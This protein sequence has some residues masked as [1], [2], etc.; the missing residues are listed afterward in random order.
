MGKKFRYS[1]LQKWRELKKVS[2]H[3][4]NPFDH[5]KCTEKRF[6]PICMIHIIY[7]KILSWTVVHAASYRPCWNT[8]ITWKKT[9]VIARGKAVPPGG[10]SR[11]FAKKMFSTINLVEIILIIKTK[12]IRSRYSLFWFARK[13]T[14]FDCWRLP[15]QR[16]FLS[17]ES[18]KNRVW[19]TGSR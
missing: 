1:Q 11:S 10:W 13:I 7:K 4:K 16:W 14:S 5:L 8:Q 19:S 17:R 15:L 2:N 6:S 18:R 9:V 3:F 12:C